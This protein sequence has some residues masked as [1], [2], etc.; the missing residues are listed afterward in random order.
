LTERDVTHLVD[1]LGVRVVV[2][3]R[4]GLEVE[5]EGEGPLLARADVRHR[6]LYPEKGTYTDVVIGEYDTDDNPYVKYYLAYLRDRPDSFVGALEDIAAGPGPVIVHCAAGKDR[7]GM[8]VALA[9]AAV[10]VERQAIVA[11][12]ALTGERIGA[13]MR[14]L[15]SS[16]TYRSELEGVTDESRLPRAEYLERVLEVLDERHGGAAG[17]LGAQG[18]G[19]DD[20]AALRERLVA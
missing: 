12:Y 16:E 7:T 11:D 20:Q 8:V 14:R 3:L 5:Q 10:G 1:D 9:L 18:F 6:S 15:R 2:D 4:S 13:I 17:W 19:D